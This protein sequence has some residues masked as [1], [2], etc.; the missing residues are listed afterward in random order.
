MAG[1]IWTIQV[2]H[3]ALFRQVGV[4]GWS[5]YHAAHTR[6]MTGVVLPAMVVELGSSGLLALAPPL[7]AA[8]PLLLLSLALAALTW[9]ATFLVSVPLHARLSQGWD[10]AVGAA[11]VRTNWARTALWTA[12]ALVMLIVLW[13]LLRHV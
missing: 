10:D 13:F 9:A 4:A 2:V 1:V 8:R 3:Y 12:H 11:L 6:R 5:S 7:G